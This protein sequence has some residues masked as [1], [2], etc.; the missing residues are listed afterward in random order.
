MD[1]DNMIGLLTRRQVSK[2]TTLSRTTLWR[3]VR[4]EVFPA[5]FNT[6]GGRLVWW[7]ADV[8]R[9]MHELAPRGPGKRGR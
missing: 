1:R 5:P 9:W 2:L 3:Y 6:P 8:L 7:M 4:D